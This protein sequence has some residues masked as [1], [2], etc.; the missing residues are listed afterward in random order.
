[1]LLITFHNPQNLLNKLREI[2]FIKITFVLLIKL[3]HHLLY[4]LF[5]GL[6]YV[7]QLRSGYHYLL[8]LGLLYSLIVI[9]VDGLKCSAC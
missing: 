3:F 9:D 2:I 6:L 7:H 1:M 4:L 8:K 5:G